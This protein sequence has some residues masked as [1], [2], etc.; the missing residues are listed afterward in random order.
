SR[1]GGALAAPSTAS[2]PSSSTGSGAPPSSGAQTA[3][4]SSGS[5]GAPASGSTGAP[6][7]LPTPSG[8]AGGPRALGID[9]A[10]YQHTIDWPTVKKLGGISFGIARA[11]HGIHPDAS[12]ARNW[13]G[14]KQEKIIRGAY[15]FF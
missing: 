5:I 8:P 14:M 12:F 4:P 2:G 13:P 10:A 1:S 7:P 15:H 9:V 11:T 3:P 6:Q